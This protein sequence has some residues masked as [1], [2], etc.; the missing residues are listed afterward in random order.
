MQ[1][2]VKKKV[3]K[4]YCPRFGQV[5]IELEFIT[6][7]QLKSALNIQVDD[8]TTGREHRLLGRIMFDHRVGCEV[9]QTEIPW[10]GGAERFTGRSPTGE[11]A[12]GRAKA[13]QELLPPLGGPGQA[14]EVFRGRECRI[15]HDQ[16]RASRGLHVLPS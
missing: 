12:R 15:R 14:F 4:K 7:E 9:S 16:H 10:I 8:E 6:V 3:S 11:H 1:R 2:T 5:A 13:L